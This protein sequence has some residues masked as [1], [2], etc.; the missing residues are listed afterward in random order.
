MFGGI[1]RAD[2]VLP[3]QSHRKKTR[4]QNRFTSITIM[5]KN[6]RKKKQFTAT[7]HHLNTHTHLH[8]H[9][10]QDQSWMWISIAKDILLNG[11]VPAALDERFIDRL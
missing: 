4:T 3:I 6:N 10:A 1:N 11:L 8:S 9:I 5:I 7:I 2:L